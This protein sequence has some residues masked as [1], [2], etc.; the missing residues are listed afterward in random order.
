MQAKGECLSEWELSCQTLIFAYFAVQDDPSS[1]S[2]TCVN[3][4][5]YLNR[6]IIAGGD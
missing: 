5:A 2:L 6:R 3:V 1:Q 4:Q